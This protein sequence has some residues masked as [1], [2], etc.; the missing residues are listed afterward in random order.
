MFKVKLPYLFYLHSKSSASKQESHTVVTEVEIVW[1]R[2]TRSYD[3]AGAEL[4]GFTF[5]A[6][7][8]YL[9]NTVVR[10]SY[11]TRYPQ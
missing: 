8:E 11:T 4:D 2:S 10:I 1:R 5:F 6:T 3:T 9:A 7:S